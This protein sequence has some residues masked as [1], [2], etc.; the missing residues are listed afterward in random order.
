VT[1]AVF[2]ERS[3]F[4]RLSIVD[5]GDI[6]SGERDRNRCSPMAAAQ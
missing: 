1:S 2:P 4:M 3:I 5:D 6:G